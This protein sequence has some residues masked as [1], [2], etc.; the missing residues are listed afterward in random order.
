MDIEAVSC[1]EMFVDCTS[2]LAYTKVNVL[3]FAS[4]LRKEIQVCE[5]INFCSNISWAVINPDIFSQE[6]TGCTCSTGFGP[7]R[8]IARLATKKAKPDGQYYVRSEQSKDF[9]GDVL[10][11]ELPG[12]IKLCDQSCI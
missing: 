11:S 2:L 3:E 12:E 5:S 10:V 8:L 4:I 1:D 9:I 6:I 7:N